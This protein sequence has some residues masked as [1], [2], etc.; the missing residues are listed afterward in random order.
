MR[1]EG[2]T[3]ETDG[4]ARG[5]LALGSGAPSVSRLQSRYVRGRAGTQDEE[6]TCWGVF[7]LTPCREEVETRRESVSVMKV[8][9][10]KGQLGCIISCL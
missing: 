8:R 4:D 1:V 6:S 9:D 2:A 10:G 3:T 7:L 5:K